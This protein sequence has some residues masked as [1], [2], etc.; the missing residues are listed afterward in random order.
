M[1]G[2]SFHESPLQA[3]PSLCSHKYEGMVK[4]ILELV[5]GALGEATTLL[6][7]EVVWDLVFWRKL[8]ISWDTPKCKGRPRTSK[9]PPKPPSQIKSMTWREASDKLLNMWVVVLYK[10]R[11]LN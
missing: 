4:L 8:G 10:F 5:R 9:P 2:P 6:G 7:G 11:R 1:P 3:I